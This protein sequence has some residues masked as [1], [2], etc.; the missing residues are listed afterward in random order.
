MKEEV[1]EQEE[2]REIVRDRYGKIA[3]E[4]EGGCSG[5]KGSCCMPAGGGKAESLSEI[6]GYSAEDLEQIPEGADLGLGCG[7][8]LQEARIVKGMT[9]LDLGSG[10][11]IDVFLAARLVGENGFV[12]G[13]DMTPDMIVRSRK[14]AL[15]SGVKNAQ[16]RLGEIEH[17]PVADSSVDLVISN[18]VINLSPEKDKVFAEVYRVLRPG[19]RM[20]FS[21]VIARYDF[22]DEIRY[23]ADLYSGCMAGAQTAHAIETM[24]QNAGFEGGRVEPREEGQRAIDSWSRGTEMSDRIFSGVI[25]GKKPEGAL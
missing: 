2:I 14:C 24:M 21:D 22:P 6:M 1:S 13:V 12:I 3:R 4:G 18:C 15:K 9:V 25:S 17:L 5:G 7:A 11:G 10:A 8:P 23:N 16:F 19:G 20:V